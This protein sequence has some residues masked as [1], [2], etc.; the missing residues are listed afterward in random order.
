M[1]LGTLCYIR[2]K[3]STLLLFRNKKKNDVMGGYWIG[4]GGK[5][6]IEIGETPHE[7]IVREVKEESGLSVKPKLR[8]IITFRDLDPGVED[9]YAYIFTATEI[10]GSLIASNE[11]DLKWVGDDELSKLNI[12]DGDRIFLKWI[13]ETDKIFSAKFEY[14]G[15]KLVRHSEVFYS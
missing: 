12:T 11:G 7:C 4:L 9:W 14:Q 2:K 13:I 6:D 3:N 5:I 10:E 15:F 8:G 1:I